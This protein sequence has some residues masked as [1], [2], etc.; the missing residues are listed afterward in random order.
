[1]PRLR[2][3][4]EKR[5]D[6]GHAPRSVQGAR[7]KRRKRRSGRRR[8]VEPAGAQ[9]SLAVGD[10]AAGDTA[11][12]LGSPG[13]N[14]NL[15]Q[16]VALGDSPRDPTPLPPPRAAREEPPPAETPADTDTAA[17]TESADQVPAPLTPEA[18]VAMAESVL[19]TVGTIFCASTGRDFDS[20]AEKTCTYSAESRARMLAWAPSAVPYVQGFLG[21]AQLV[22][23]CMFGFVF[24]SSTA[25]AVGELKKLPRRSKTKTSIRPAGPEDLPAATPADDFAPFGRMPH[26]SEKWQ[27]NGPPAG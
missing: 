18:L 2:K 5:T 10:N 8:Q 16:N 23:A 24:V 11:A 12:G 6:D 27:R 15:P 19:V 4:D 20:A 14:L 7:R 9:A 21:D 25:A 26:P 1:M 3:T 13:R 17:D 22:G